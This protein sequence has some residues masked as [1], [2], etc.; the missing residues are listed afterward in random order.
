MPDDPPSH[1]LQALRRGMI[2]YAVLQVILVGTA[3]AAGDRPLAG[4]VAMFGVAMGVA[5][6]DA[7][8]SRVELAR[9]RRAFGEL[10]DDTDRA[11]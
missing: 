7:V 11:I 3:L 4:V 8:R 5:V 9:Y 2:V 6:A 1:R 10:P